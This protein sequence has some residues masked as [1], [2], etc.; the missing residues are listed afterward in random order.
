MNGKLAVLIPVY[1]G[2]QLLRESVESCSVSGL[3]PDSYEIIV[4]DNCSTDG[5]VDLLPKETANGATIQVHRNSSNLGRIGNW[6]RAVE[7]AEEQGFSWVAF[8]FVGDVWIADGSLPRILALMNADD[9]DF[10]FTS[11]FIWDSRT[12]SRF[13]APRISIRGHELTMDTNSF[14][15]RLLERGQLPVCPLQCNIYSLKEP[16]LLRFDPADPLHTDSVSTISF[17]HRMKGRTLIMSEPF[18]AWKLHANRFFSSG[19]ILEIPAAAFCLLQG[20]EQLTGITV[21]WT[22]AKSAFVYDLL[23]IAAKFEKSYRAPKLLMRGI[24][25]AAS[26]PGRL[27][28]FDILGILYRRLILH[29][30]PVHL[31]A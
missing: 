14:L 15:A 25:Y 10:A 18:M 11:Y 6:N 4:V 28:P 24:K 21:N 17:L 22:K 30:N 8:L 1:N 19:D 7:I 20:A 16:G 29:K 27:D 2:G 23:V 12:N 5:A 31:E 13:L 26:R 9:L 3:S